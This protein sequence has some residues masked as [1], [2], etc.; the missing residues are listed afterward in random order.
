[1]TTTTAEKL[2]ELR[3]KL[4]IA[5]EPAGEIAIAKRAKKGIPSARERIDML[6]DKGSFVEI[7]ALM[8]TPGREDAFYGDAVVVGHGTVDGRPVAVFSHDQTVLGGSVGE[9][10]GRKV[11][12]VLDYALKIGC[13]VVGI[14][15]SGGAR[16]QDAVTSLAWYGEIGKRTE[17]LSGLCPQ[18]SVIVGKCAGG[19]V[20]APINTDVVVAT[21][22]AYMFVTGPDVI[23]AVTGE[24]VSLHELGSARKQ[25]EYGNVHHVAPDEKAAFDWVR[26][27]LSYMPSNAQEKPPV[28][29]PGLEPEITP[30]DLELDSFMPDAD[31]SGYD[32]H[33]ILLKIFDDGDFFEVR[34]Q[35]AANII[36][37][38]AR[39]DG[40]PVGVVANQPLFLSGAL[41]A[42]AADKAAHF[43]RVCDAYSIPLVFVVD[44]P[45]FLPG[46]EQEKIGVIKRGGRFLF[47]YVEA[48]VPKVTVVVRKSYGGGYAVM[49]SKQ[50]GADINFAW[51]TARIAVM[52]AESAVA[53]IGRKQIAEAGDNAPAV[54]RQLINFYNEHVATPYIAAE[55]GYIDAVIDPAST[56]LEIRRALNLLRDKTVFKNPRKHHLLPL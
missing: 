2:A 19:A 36:T 21:E 39:V 10:F 28:V 11:S 17:P 31:N 49:G 34:S 14:N 51:P 6:L 54:R 16:V 23:K 52:G 38:Y 32:M 3:Q 13:P 50:L 20:Y 53:V 27:Y 35:T 41:D 37:G 45:G 30:D 56:R 5:Q 42:A 15:D 33:D 4:E 29:N 18:I 12:A 25:A 7:G 48:S 44:T 22:E 8:K 46:V 40:R 55:R 24:D 47:S 26:Q 1:M 9:M 43:V